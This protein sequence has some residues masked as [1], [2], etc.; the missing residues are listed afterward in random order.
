MDKTLR[1]V[2]KAWHSDLV[3]AFLEKEALSASWAKRRGMMPYAGR[4]L[5]MIACWLADELQRMPPAPADS[6]SHFVTAGWDL[7]LVLSRKSSRHGRVF[8]GSSAMSW[9]TAPV[10]RWTRPSGPS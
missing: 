2:R 6:C 1:S 8:T 10:G 7:I 3:L 9:S 5:V 4:P